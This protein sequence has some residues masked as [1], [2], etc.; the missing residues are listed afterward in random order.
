MDRL[1]SDF[2]LVSGLARK[3]EFER[4]LASTAMSIVVSARHVDLDIRVAIKLLAPEAR[5][6]SVAVSRFRREARAAAK[7]QSQHVVRII[8]VSSTNDGYPYFVM[9][10][11]DG[12]NLKELLDAYPLRRAPLVDA[13]DFVLQASDAV[14]E[15]HT[16]GIVHRDL[17]PANL[18]HVERGDGVP[19]IKVLDFGISKS[20]ASPGEADRTDRYEIL[21]TPSYMSPEQIEGSSDVD[22]RT[23]IWSL[24]VV[25]Y[26]AIAGRAPFSGSS[27]AELWNRVRYEVPE[28]LPVLR[29][30]CSS[31]LWQTI[32][33]C[34][35]KNPADR[36]A[37]LG[38]FAQALS[39]LGSE[40]PRPSIAR[41]RFGSEPGGASDSFLR[42]SCSHVPQRRVPMVKERFL[43][44]GLLGLVGTGL[45]AAAMLVD[46]NLG[47]LSAAATRQRAPG[48]VSLLAQAPSVSERLES[49]VSLG[50]PES[51]VTLGGRS[52]KEVSKGRK[53]PKVA[54]PSPTTS[55]ARPSSSETPSSDLAAARRDSMEL[56]FIIN[57][58]TTR[59]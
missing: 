23:D 13:I 15:G 27:T 29:K 36:Y 31:E 56:R 32:A 35:Q 57:P 8:D 43:K 20:A 40:R 9:E 10:Y 30:D 3:Y 52:S 44:F 1:P 26:E 14:C 38:E 2:W 45:L 59:K 39:R 4:Q 42:V 28:P 6:S 47:S 41:V 21:G 11:L 7:I 18:F 17:K 46:S 25:L 48:E 54:K 55:T 37:N 5:R 58:I 50:P 12:R 34:L 19:I 53:I 33:K 16:L 22:H 24:G 49:G 51:V